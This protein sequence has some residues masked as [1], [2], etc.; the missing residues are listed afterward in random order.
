MGS[1]S[2]VS[3]IS[4]MYVTNSAACANIAT[5]YPEGWLQYATNTTDIYGVRK[6]EDFW[7]L[8]VCH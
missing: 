4:Q 2:H 5:R 6:S 7:S 8:G 3:L 1:S